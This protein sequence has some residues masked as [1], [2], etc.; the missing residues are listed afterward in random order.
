VT[1][2]AT[3]PQEPSP[4]DRRRVTLLALVSLCINGPI[5]VYIFCT[6]DPRGDDLILLLTFIGLG[7]SGLGSLFG[8]CWGL[9]GIVDLFEHCQ[10][11]PD[12]AVKTVATEAQDEDKNVEEED[13]ENVEEEGQ[14]EML[15]LLTAQRGYAASDNIV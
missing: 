4:E 5:Y 15:E 2:P 12:S 1:T 7:V 9:A 13:G 6:I 8:L 11:K 10:K 14:Q 3:T